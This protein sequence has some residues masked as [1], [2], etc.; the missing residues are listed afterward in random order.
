MSLLLVFTLVAFFLQK[1]IAEALFKKGEDPLNTVI[2]I[3]NAKYR[4]IGVLAEKGSSMGF[5]GDNF[6][7]IPLKNVQL[8]VGDTVLMGRFKNN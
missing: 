5:G 3:G 4:I 8:D 7:I 6:C 1:E 2:G